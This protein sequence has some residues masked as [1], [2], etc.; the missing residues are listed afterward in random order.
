MLQAL[1]PEEIRTAAFV[2][3]Q[4]YNKEKKDL[5]NYLLA[6][7]AIIQAT[8]SLAE[9]LPDQALA[10]KMVALMCSYNMSAACWP[11]WN[12]SLPNIGPADLD[13]GLTFAEFNVEFG[14]ELQ[15]GPERK[16]NG[17][18][19]LGA[20]LAVRK[21]YAEAY[22]AFTASRD[23]AIEAEDKDGEMMAKGWCLAMDHLQGNEAAKGQLDIL[24]VE[25]GKLG[26]DGEFY[27][28]QYQPFFNYLTG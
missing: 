25:L 13:V 12:D 10:Y 18:W 11:A 19:I 28:S 26:E 6:A 14:K 22:V 23:F 27:A 9:Q 4:T 3:F 2:A 1:T 7:R 16:K 21:K 17:C 8:L 20:Q 24:I 15:L 5:Q